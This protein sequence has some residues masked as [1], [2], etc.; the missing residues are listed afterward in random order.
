MSYGTPPRRPLPNGAPAWR[1]RHLAQHLHDL[2]PRALY[3][4]LR[5][6]LDR[7]M[8][9]AQAFVDRLERYARL[10]PE[11]MRAI[12]GYEIPPPVLDITWT[13]RREPLEPDP[14]PERDI[15]ERPEGG[16]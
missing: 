9:D 11:A 3:E 8:P 2:G 15:R 13:F 10:P 6:L 7:Q 12:G 16:R 5:E 14:P 1:L 4:F